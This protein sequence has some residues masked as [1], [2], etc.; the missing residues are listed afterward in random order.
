MTSADQAFANLSLDSWHY[1]RWFLPPADQS[2]HPIVNEIEQHISSRHLELHPFFSLAESSKLAL[3]L[4]VCQELVMTNAFS[5]IVLAAAS[6]IVNVHLRAMLS[7]VA[8][9]EHGVFRNG[10]ARRAHPWLLNQLRESMGIAMDAV[11]PAGP[12]LR[13]IRRLVEASAKPL[14]GVAAIGV[15]NE[16]LIIPEYTAIKK[17]FAKCAPIVNYDEFLDA[18]LSEDVGHSQLCYELA[19][20]MIAMGASVEEYRKAAIASVD[21]RIAY[22]DE[23]L[24]LASGK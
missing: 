11:K 7:E 2:I 1:E 20:A 19:S 10:A 9:G 17:C 21:S 18:N 15:G 12:T 6:S 13:F 3:E 5:Q 4:W 8:F 16:R 22:F 24:L 23:L 14:S